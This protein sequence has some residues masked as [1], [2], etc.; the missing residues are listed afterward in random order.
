MATP[1]RIRADG[2]ESRRR[3]LDA[4]AELAGERGFDGTTIAAVSERSGLPKSSIYWHFEDKDT[5]IATVVE[6]SYRQWIERIKA[7][8]TPADHERLGDGFARSV[9]S[10]TDSPDFLR[11]GLMLT[12]DKR[13][14]P[15]P[16]RQRFVA[17]R[18]E[19][20]AN[21]HEL[22]RSTFPHLDENAVASLGHLTMAL[23]DG[24]FIANEAGE[25]E[26]SQH[27]TLITDA[28]LG[29]AARLSDPSH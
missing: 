29:A 9:Q 6:D 24:F 20:Q 5:L 28:V 27:H 7:A 23:T 13:S 26:L 25:L 14:E 10:I 15:T 18:A 17:I 21:L 19:V 8:T 4:T 2:K 16:A 1:R 22:Y 3:I 11:L 12:L